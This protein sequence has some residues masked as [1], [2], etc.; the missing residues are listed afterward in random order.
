VV[1][2]L[3]GRLRGAVLSERFPE[4][5]QGAAQVRPGVPLVTLWPQ[6]LGEVPPRVPPPLGGQVAQ[7]PSLSRTGEAVLQCLPRAAQA[8]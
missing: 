3:H 6:K 8:A 4:L 7:L 1:P 2:L 5:G